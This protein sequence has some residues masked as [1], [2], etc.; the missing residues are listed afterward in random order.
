MGRPA[1]SKPDRLAVRLASM[2]QP[3]FGQRFTR[4][5]S[6]TSRFENGSHL[7]RRGRAIRV[8][9]GVVDRDLDVISGYVGI[10]G[11]RGAL[12][13]WIAHR[14]DAPGP[15]HGRWRDGRARTRMGVVE[16]VRLADPR[17][18]MIYP[19]DRPRSRAQAVAP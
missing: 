13:R 7:P 12:Y 6:K 19:I 3:P 17:I 11:R 16:V 2:I 4:P 5:N 15:G 18:G 9:T 10:H 8:Q 14:A 1:E